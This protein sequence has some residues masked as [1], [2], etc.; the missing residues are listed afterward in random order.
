M[1]SLACWLWLQDPS[2]SDA[3]DGQDTGSLLRMREGSLNSV[4]IIILPGEPST[5]VRV[6]KKVFS[7]MG[8]AAGTVLQR[9][10]VKLSTAVEKLSEVRVVNV[11][12]LHLDG[13]CSPDTVK[14]PY[15]YVI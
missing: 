3:C 15:N 9:V 7:L 8:A 2:S 13:E 12:L 1:C 5:S 6:E 11:L 14:D 10:S 4:G